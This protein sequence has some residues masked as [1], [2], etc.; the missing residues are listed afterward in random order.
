[1]N[2]TSVH[3]FTRFMQNIHLSGQ[4]KREARRDLPTIIHDEQV[5][6]Y[7]IPAA[8]SSMAVVTDLGRSMP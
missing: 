6:I 2:M 4:K 8:S 7:L 3:Q 1:M 5:E